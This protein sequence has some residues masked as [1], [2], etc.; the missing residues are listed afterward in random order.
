MMKNKIWLLDD[1]VVDMVTAIQKYYEL[2]NK[3][4]VLQFFV[5]IVKTQGGKDLEN[6]VD[7]YLKWH[8]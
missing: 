8:C 3:N 7:G 2:K 4:E 5:N 1:E 6:F